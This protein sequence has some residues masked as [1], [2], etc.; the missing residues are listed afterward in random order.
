MKGIVMSGNGRPMVP[1]YGRGID[2]I[3]ANQLGML[4]GQ[5]TENTARSVPWIRGT[6]SNEPDPRRNINH[7]CGLPDTADLTPQLLF[8]LYNRNSIAA[9]VVEVMPKESW[10]VQPTVYEDEEE[11]PTEFEN[12]WDELGQSIGGKGWYQDEKGSAI[13]DYLGRVDV[14]SGIGRYGVVLLGL[15]DGKALWEPADGIDEHGKQKKTSSKQINF[16]R[17]LPETL[18]PVSSWNGDINSPRYSLPERYSIT[19]VDPTQAPSGVS[20][21]PTKTMEVHWT[22]V[23]HVVDNSHHYS[24]S[25][26]LSVSRLQPVFDNI[27]GLRKIYNS[28]PEGY[29]RW[30][31]PWISFETHPQLGGDVDVDVSALRDMFED[32][33]NSLQRAMITKGMNAK[34]ISGS[35]QDP[36]NQIKAQL[37]AICVKIGVPMRIFLGSE[38]G[39]LASS[40]DQ[41]AWEWRMY[42][43]FMKY[44][45]PRIICPFVDR[46][47]LLGVLPEPEG[48][49][50]HREKPGAL[51][52]LERAQVA[53]SHV[54]TMAA[55]LQ[56]GVESLMTPSRLFTQEFG[57]EEEEVEAQMEEAAELTEERE[58]EDA[59][60][61]E[62]QMKLA[63]AAAAPD[64]ELAKG[65]GAIASKAPPSA[66]DATSSPKNVPGEKKP[67]PTANYSSK[68]ARDKTGK[69]TTMGVWDVAGQLANA[70]AAAQ[71]A[72]MKEIGIKKPTELLDKWEGLS[73]EKLSSVLKTIGG[74]SS[75]G[76]QKPAAPVK[77]PVA[78]AVATA[79]PVK[80]AEEKPSEPKES[81]TKQ[82]K[83]KEPQSVKGKNDMADPVTEGD[84]NMCFENARKEYLTLKKEGKDAK[85]VVGKVVGEI[86][87]A[88]KGSKLEFDHAWV[89][90]GG[91]VVDPSPYR[92]DKGDIAGWLKSDRKLEPAKDH[93]RAVEYQ[94]AGYASD[95]DL[96]KPLEGFPATK[97]KGKKS[98]VK[99]TSNTYWR[100]IEGGDE[101]VSKL[102]GETVTINEVTHV[103]PVRLDG[104]G[105]PCAI[106]VNRGQCVYDEG[107]DDFLLPRGTRLKFTSYSHGNG[108]V[109]EVLS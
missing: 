12:A 78:P 30:V 80:P 94:A 35:T 71:K 57:Y 8:E 3:T 32:V 38:R 90:V 52:A 60:K 17:V 98:V 26:V 93:W 15:D 79:A 105:T 39:E 72:A 62:E 43:R 100:L 48:Y 21:E 41:N 22:R 27:Y 36:L 85:Y 89:E 82:S 69:W 65:F 76:P 67:V 55:Y 29:W 47:I 58:E 10:K 46:L 31:F 37:E 14:A 44:C 49:S 106:T 1:V 102:V 4:Y 95:K 108:L 16:L 77:P 53:D 42:D 74:T 51:S 18:A 92:Q 64:E 86:E 107:T 25:E 34:T 84:L 20:I 45:V 96:K 66:A 7:E 24:T 6:S 59:A 54:K 33:Q 11:K 40:Q 68:Q 9:R 101:E 23:L 2:F 28:A 50:V 87:G 103:S 109:A 83:V 19:F 5:M 75:L 88:P 70:P 73:S 81:K 99:P 91:K 61:Q 104:E 56:G 13:W 97:T 63:E